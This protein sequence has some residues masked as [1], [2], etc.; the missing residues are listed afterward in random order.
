MAERTTN[1]RKR[2][3][4]PLD[5]FSELLF[6]LIMVLTFTCSLN[7][8]QASRGDLRT[9]FL[10]ALGCN[11]AWGII[12]A[13]MYLMACLSKN[14]HNI[15][16]LRAL[17]LT[18]D[19]DEGRR[20]IADALPPL[21]VSVLPPGEFELMRQKLNQIPDLPPRP[22]LI[23]NDWLGALGVFLLVFASTLPPI[24]PFL[25]SIRDVRLA[26]RISNAIALV[27]LVFTGYVYGSYAEHRPWGWAI[28]MVLIGGS[29]VG[30]A[31]ALGG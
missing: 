9:M 25:F 12:D 8:A 27:M 7:A 6:G 11:V 19:P 14:G 24:I 1:S 4:E 26:V 31:I 23:R 17:R 22:S 10:G 20:I 29:M 16:L 28:S 15:A 30:L 18:S 3:L 21:L 5:R 13:V 2:V